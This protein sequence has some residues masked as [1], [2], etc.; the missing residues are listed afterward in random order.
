M[1]SVLSILFGLL[2]VA[3]CL[4]IGYFVIKAAVKAGVLAAAEDFRVTNVV[5]RIRSE[6]EAG[7]RPLPTPQPGSS[8]MESH[9]PPGPYP[10]QTRW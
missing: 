7:G 3:A 2:V 10:P 1:L 4:V 6:I 8:G 9:H 5:A